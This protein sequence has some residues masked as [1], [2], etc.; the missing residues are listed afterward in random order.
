MLWLRNTE[1]QKNYKTQE[2]LEIIAFFAELPNL[3]ATVVAIFL[4]RS[5]IVLV[6]LLSSF[7]STL[8]N[9]AVTLLS[10]HLKKE[11]G[12]IFN[13]GV[14][15]IE[16]MAAISCNMLMIIGFSCA[17]FYGIYT[18]FVVSAPSDKLY[19]FIFIK[20]FNISFDLWFLLQNKR[21]AKFR[22]NTVSKTEIAT[23]KAYLLDDLIVFTATV[24]SY[25]FR[26]I[27][28]IVYFAPVFSGCNALYAISICI[29]EIKT[30]IKDLIDLAPSVEFQDRVADI[31]FEHRKAFQTISFIN[32]KKS[33]TCIIIELGL[34]FSDDTTFAQQI[35][36]MDT[37]SKELSA[38]VGKCDL[39]LRP[40]K[41]C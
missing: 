4:T 33:S 11:N 41:P 6:D 24:F 15:K 37:L 25:L 21:N 18:C 7:G 1:Y 23:Y 13:Y 26:H 29:K 10:H 28:W 3:I 38:K 22:N 19:M 14:E 8:H 27:S 35:D 32:F 40:C 16:A 36:L 5:G 2:K 12:D 9:A 17:V 30:N 20:G 31:I 34:T 39:L